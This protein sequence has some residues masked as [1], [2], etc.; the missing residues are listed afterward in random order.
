[1]LDLLLL[2]EEGVWRGGRAEG[3]IK[4]L[5][6]KSREQ[7]ARNQQKGPKDQ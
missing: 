2:Q 5:K 1:M 7:N 4:T 3:A 6:C